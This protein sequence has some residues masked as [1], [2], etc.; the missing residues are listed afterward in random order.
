M[1]EQW[2]PVEGY[3]GLYEVSSA[4]RVKSLA[5]IAVY[6][7]GRSKP[8]SERILS[9]KPG[10]QGYPLVSL[11]KNGKSKTVAVHQLVAKAFIG[12]CPFLGAEVRHR[13]DV[14]THNDLD[15]LVWGTR[16]ENSCDR[17]R[18][19]KGRPHYIH[20]NAKLTARDV[21]AIEVLLARTPL[22]QGEIADLFDVSQSAISRISKNVYSGDEMADGNTHAA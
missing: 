6:S 2:L 12:P 22:S 21:I 4:G 3:E 13:D 20:P 18:N 17:W 11:C 5:R 19:A 16:S 7:D 1:T 8:L 9:G 10:T 14:K 15:N